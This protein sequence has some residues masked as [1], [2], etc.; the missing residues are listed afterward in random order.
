MGIGE[1]FFAK[2]VATRKFQRDSGEIIGF[3][4]FWAGGGVR[5]EG[6]HFG[7]WILILGGR[8]GV[9][10]DGNKFFREIELA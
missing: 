8:D 4:A 3:V 5:L 10:Y 6:F 9:L 7:N 2:T 1:A